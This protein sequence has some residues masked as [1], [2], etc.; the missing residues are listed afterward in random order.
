MSLTRYSLMLPQPRLTLVLVLVWLL[1]NNSMG[2][3][4]ILLGLLLGWLIPLFTRRFWPETLQLHAPLTL[5]R[6]VGVVLWDILVANL[7]VA[8]LILGQPGQLRPAFFEVPLDLKGEIG[9]S[10][11]ANTISLTPGTVSLEL[12]SDHAS[13]RVHALDAP[14][15]DALVQEIKAR[16]EAPLKK[17]FE[18]CSPSS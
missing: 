9:I 7:T 16:Y 14:A 2:P 18:P 8:R 13:L 3:G 17:V 15:P 6:F 1:L 5:L 11:L 12:S 10:L 4:Q